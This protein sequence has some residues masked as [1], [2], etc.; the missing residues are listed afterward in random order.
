MALPLRRITKL[1]IVYFKN[2]VK[3]CSMSGI[4]T[5]SL[6][7]GKKGLFLNSDVSCSASLLLLLLHNVSTLLQNQY[8]HKVLCL[9][10]H[11]RKSELLLF[12]IYES[13]V[14]FPKFPIVNIHT[15]NK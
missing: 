14:S 2:S 6:T 1:S 4:Q 10:Q 13:K 5:I 15:S 3:I 7:I 8:S 12:V 9:L 11:L